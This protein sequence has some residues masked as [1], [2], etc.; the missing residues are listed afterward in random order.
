MDKVY[1]EGHLVDFACDIVG[2]HNLRVEF[3]VGVQVPIVSA[4]D[5]EA[6]NPF[7]II[8]IVPL[9]VSFIVVN[10]EVLDEVPILVP[11]RIVPSAFKFIGVGVVL[12]PFP[13][14]PKMSF[15]VWS[16]VE[17]CSLVISE[18]IIPFR[19]VILTFRRIA[20]VVGDVWHGI[21]AG[22]VVR[23][24]WVKHRQRSFVDCLSTGRLPQGHL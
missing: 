19:T 23:V 5:L 13:R 16:D 1:V 11:E 18:A 9:T 6:A 10:L 20:N 7:A 3:F 4:V 17:E 22:A 15:T 12:V 21:A 2:Q 8:A 24:P 14:A